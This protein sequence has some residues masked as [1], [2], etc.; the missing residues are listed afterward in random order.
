MKKHLLIL[1]T[2]CNLFLISS[3]AFA[4]DKEE[5]IKS[6]AELKAIQ[7]WSENTINS[8][9][10]E[11]DKEKI[12]EIKAIKAKANEALNSPES[13]RLQSELTRKDISKA[14]KLLEQKGFTSKEDNLI[15]QIPRM[16]LL[17]EDREKYLERFL[18]ERNKYKDYTLRRQE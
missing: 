17:E 12:A 18:E 7:Q 14:E 9:D 6:L 8:L 15:D 16:K 10:P 3:N 11:T 4:L 2:I 1:I 13:N 5:V